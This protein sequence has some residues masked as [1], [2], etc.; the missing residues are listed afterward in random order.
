MYTSEDQ[1]RYKNVGGEIAKVTKRN[2]GRGG[3]GSLNILNEGSAIFRS[4]NFMHYSVFTQ[5]TWFPSKL[6]IRH[7]GVPRKK[8]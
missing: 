7:I 3:E 5:V 8:A 2:R 1:Y 4:S 6:T